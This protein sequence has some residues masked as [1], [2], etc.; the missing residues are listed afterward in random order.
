MKKK[1]RIAFVSF[2][3][4]TNFHAPAIGRSAYL[5]DNYHAG[6][7]FGK[8]FGMTPRRV[9]NEF[10]G[11]MDT[12]DELR[13]WE[14]I[15]ILAAEGRPAGCLDQEFFD[16]LKEDVAT[17][18]KAALPVDAVFFAEHGAAT[19]TGDF[20]PDGTLFAL[21]R[22]IVGPDAPIVAALDLHANVSP[23]MFGAVDMFCSYLTNPHV[24]LYERGQESARAVD[25]MLRGQKTAKAFVK[26]PLIPPATSQ[27]TKSG[28]YGDLIDYG[29]AQVSGQV[30][31][32][33]ICS[34]FSLGDTPKNGMSVAVTTRDNLELARIT[35]QRIGEYAWNDRHRYT[36]DL[37]PLDEAVA[38]M[39]QRNV[40]P[41]LPALIFADPAD[42]PGGGG[43]GNTTY[44]LKAM[45]DADVKDALIGCMYDPPLAQKAHTLGV[46]AKFSCTF[47]S[48]ESAK[49]SEPLTCEVVVEGLHQGDIEGRRGMLAGAKIN[50]GPSALLRIGGVQVAV[51]SERRQCCD[52]MMIECLGVDLRGLRSLVVK[53]RGHFRAGFDDLFND[54]QIVEVDVPGL[55]T[56][57]LSQ[58]PYQNVPRPIYPLDPDMEWEV[59]V[60][61][62]FD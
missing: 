15:P 22:Q 49:F 58:V 34:G 10:V 55:T 20:D 28:P 44:I 19:T 62:E 14:M 33:S 54:D 21:A 40:D 11:F 42:N 30:M 1:V 24:D 2:R 9:L 45:I 7:E 25:E 61:T 26:L 27:N 57:V 18:L 39:L 59:W 48:Q 60:Q 51:I 17:R 4:E 13:E 29:Q 31:N 53:S 47:N 52:P 35:A 23:K 5:P 3:L 46:G 56:P 12:M 50:N 8:L 32:V 36:T 16:E 38:L 6:D 43:R 37:T 41:S